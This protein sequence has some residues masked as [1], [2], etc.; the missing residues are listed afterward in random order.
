MYDNQTPSLRISRSIY[1]RVQLGGFMT[2]KR[3]ALTA[4]LA[5]SVAGTA[6]ATVVFSNNFEDNNLDPEVGSWSFG[7]TATATILTNGGATDPTLGDKVVLLDFNANNNV[8]LDLTIDFDDLDISG[9]NTAT[10]SWDSYRRRTAGTTKSI[11]VT[12]YDSLNSKIFTMVLADRNLLGSGDAE[13]QRPA[14]ETSS[15]YSLLPAPGTPGSY[16]FGAS[17]VFNAT[18]D[19]SFDLTISEDG[20]DLTTV[21]QGGTSYSTTD[22]ATFDGA[23]HSDLAYLKITSFGAGFGDVFD[24]IQVNGTLVPE[25]SS[26]ALLGLGGLAMLRRRR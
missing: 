4:L 13:R 2:T 6:S 18:K 22:L 5:F 14:Y 16:W 9:S 8:A 26:L 12:G 24:N 17:T 10:V 23:N 25:P 3:Y 7:S 11:F 15:G 21:S 20:W 1:Q 19:A